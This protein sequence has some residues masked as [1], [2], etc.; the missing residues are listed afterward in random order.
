MPDQRYLLRFPNQEAYFAAQ[1]AEADFEHVPVRNARRNYIAL[2]L[3]RDYAGSPGM[4]AQLEKDLSRFQEKYAAEVFVDFQYDLDLEQDIFDPEDFIEEAAAE[5][6]LDDVL[7]VIRAPD[8]WAGFNRGEGVAI[9]MVDTGIDGSH[10]EFPQ[11]RRIGGWAPEGQNPWT[12]ERGHGTMCAC[13]AAASRD[14]GGIFEGVAPRARLVSCKTDFWV[15]EIVAIY[16][17]LIDLRGREA[18]V[19][20]AS[21][22]YGQKTGTPPLDPPN[23][24]IF[25]EALRDAVD[26]GIHLFFSAG[27]N[28]ERTGGDPA[29]CSPTSIWLHKC[30][31][32]LMAVATCDLNARMW[33]YSSRGP[34]QRAG[35]AGNNEK[36]D[37]TAPTP[38]NGRILYGA[39]IRTLP[40]GWGTSGACPQVAALAA[41]ALTRNPGL[42]RRDLF[43][44]I[45]NSAGDLGFSA[46]CQGAGRIDVL[47]ALRSVPL[48]WSSGTP[49]GVP[50]QPGGTGGG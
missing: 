6:T 38:K 23:Q 4:N 7:R 42:P 11:A 31:E 10:R 41:I 44:I 16:D 17:Y 48:P 3:A 50:K 9:A 19:V 32:D 13:I 43:D 25:E 21:N 30:R 24:D 37:V 46:A 29:Q 28:H 36:P 20:V 45:R 27:N 47:A 39:G 34:G 40:N 12:D 14:E 33:S 18:L 8:A 1:A 22:S 26:A 15:S 35:R 5:G 2:E 49:P